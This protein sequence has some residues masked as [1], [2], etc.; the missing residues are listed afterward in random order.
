MFSSMRAAADTIFAELS[1]LKTD[2]AF[3]FQ[4]LPHTQHVTGTSALLVN[5]DRAT[6]VSAP[7]VLHETKPS[8]VDL[9]RLTTTATRLGRCTG[10]HLLRKPLRKLH[11]AV[12]LRLSCGL[13]GALTANAMALFGGSRQAASLSDTAIL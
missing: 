7:H 12:S 6:G 2:L 3:A 5:D 11:T 9:I 4:R 10:G 13:T 8:S 1:R